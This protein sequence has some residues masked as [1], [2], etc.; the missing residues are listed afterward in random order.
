M[1]FKCA[2]KQFRGLLP[3]LFAMLML[4]ATT[5]T[6]AATVAEEPE[7]KAAFVYNFTLFTTWP[8]TNDPLSLCVLGE[9]TYLPLLKIYN[10]RIVNGATLKV[11]QVDSALEALSCQVLFIDA[12]QLKNFSAIHHALE[13]LPILKVAESNSISPHSVDIAITPNNG[14]LQFEVDKTE[15]Q[16]SGLSFSYKLLKLA[17]KVH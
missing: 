4:L 14:R 16:E 10:G 1:R 7:L 9:S 2:V 5:P 12:I 15:A 8:Q 6:N 13:G 17:R 3:K 11:M